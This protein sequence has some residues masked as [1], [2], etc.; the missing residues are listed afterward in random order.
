MPSQHEGA[1]N[2]VLEAFA[3][4]T[5]VIA[6][7]IPEHKEI[8]PK[9]SLLPLADQKAWRVK[10]EAIADKSE[11]Q[12]HQIAKEQKFAASEHLQFDWDNRI[13]H[14]ILQ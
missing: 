11:S 9:V 8:L 3:T 13:V 6:S 4:G 5:P 12:L 1:P 2:A 10:I 14:C 7:D